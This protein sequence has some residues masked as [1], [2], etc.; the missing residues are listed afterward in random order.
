MND[1]HFED[2]KR[3]VVFDRYDMPTPWINYLS[4]GKMH[5]MISQAGG[6]LAFYRSP[7]IWR[8]NRYRFFHLPTDRSGLY[9]YIRDRKTGKYYSLTAE[10][11]ADKPEKFQSA[12]GMGYTYYLTEKD[13]LSARLTAFVSPDDDVLIMKA[14]LTNNADCDR[15]LDVFGY[16][17]FALMEF[18]RELQWQCYNKHQVNVFYED[19]CGAIV[20]DY[21]VEDQPR[22]EETPYIFFAA[23]RMP[24]SYDGNREKFV[25]S[26][27]SEADPVGV[28]NGTCFNTTLRGGD[29]C[30][31][32]QIPVELAA[33]DSTTVQFYLGAVAKRPDT[34]DV[35]DRVRTAGYSEAAFEKLGAK[36][37]DLLSGFACEIPDKKAERM[38]NTWNPYQVWYNFLFSRNISFYATGT[39]R[40]T[41]YR[42]TA[43]DV[44]TVA[45]I[46]NDNAKAKTRELLSQQY[47][48][49]HVN[50]YYFP[51]EG[52]DPVTTIH[53]DDHLWSILTV[54]RILAEDGNTEFLN[55]IVPF[56]DG[57]EATV[58]E[59][60][61][62]AVKFTTEH[63]GRNGFPLMLRSDWNDSLYRVCRKGLGES[64]WT[65]MQ[66]G[67]CLKQLA[68]M[69]EAIG[70]TED[71]ARYGKLYD[72]QK[73]N[74]NEKAWDGKWYRRAVTDEGVFL[75][76]ESEPQAKIWLNSQTW[77][78][79]CGYADKERGE[80]AMD[81]VYKYLNTPLGIKK[82]H[83]SMENY[84]S[85]ED[86]LTNYNKGTSENGG[87]F[88][89]ANTW[90][91]IAECM[92][93]RADRAWEYYSQLIPV[94]TME[95]AGVEVY[96]A[97]PYVYSSNIFGPESD[98][99]GY[100]NVS[101]LSG[102]AAW[103]YMAATQY[104]LGL[105]PTMKGLTVDPCVPS[106]WNEYKCTRV[107]R[108]CKFNLSFERGNEFAMYEDGVRL[109]GNLLTP[110]GKTERNIR[111]VYAS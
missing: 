14:D 51:I 83:P 100:A 35:L 91:I 26:Y 25:G 93:G 58:Y 70:K 56:Y 43:Q 45:A 94:N 88:C 10:P 74:V 44:M 73:A 92:L 59:H 81:N 69:A 102:T 6:L 50:H 5:T 76:S 16:I 110:D 84:P 80:S 47:N 12:H 28:E 105:Q 107:F 32:L 53:S 101:W 108:G 65:A 4:N 7:Q 3:E 96:R 66:F 62:L 37:N 42:D 72:E 78:V 95:K 86:P 15:S 22:R 98:K 85:A 40:G 18:M 17:E 31:A 41:G 67:I 99:F 106:D 2:D 46:T 8:I 89:H 21:A 19:D 64:I 60:L 90:A 57:G 63:L 68:E 20:Y 87:I 103:M 24:A 11:C 55:E 27:H 71:A 33:G 23:D 79:L 38:I 29:P 61:C 34:A 1:F 9:L 75:G 52:Y 36:F 48:D 77:S 39:F 104:I 13:G 109:D 30:G 97:E 111:V 49:G 82:I 54:Y